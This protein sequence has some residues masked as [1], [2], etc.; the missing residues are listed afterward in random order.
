VSDLRRYV[1]TQWDRVGGAIAILV[2]AVM[3]ISGVSAVNDKIYPGQQLPLILSS[4]I[5]GLFLL[6]LGVM[7][8]LSADLRDEWRKL[9]SIERAIRE[10]GAAW[11]EETRFDTAP[12]TPVREAMAQQAGAG[13]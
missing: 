11:R 3:L 2:G 12:S 1:L 13:R 10:E 5:G 9:D 4:G 8:W 6:G 7:L